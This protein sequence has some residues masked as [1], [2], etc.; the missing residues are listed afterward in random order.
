[1]STDYIPQAQQTQTAARIVRAV[2]ASLYSKGFTAT[3][4]GSVAADLGISKGVIH[5]HF[6]SKETLLQET[7]AYIYQT[8]FSEVRP[9]IDAAD[10]DW[11]KIEQF[12]RRSIDFHRDHADYVTALGEILTNFRP[13]Q[14]RSYA[15]RRLEQEFAEVSE[16]LVAGQRS[17]MF[18][19]FDPAIMAY[20]IRQALNGTVRYART[21]G[22]DLQHH[23]DELVALFRRS[24]VWS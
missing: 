23:A 8:A 4:I 20:T 3:S 14:H 5:Y 11:D 22:Y 16:L 10:N 6:P 9:D 1:M 17:G 24:I 12:I 7:I 15:L 21:D 19:E 13:R 2:I 18:V